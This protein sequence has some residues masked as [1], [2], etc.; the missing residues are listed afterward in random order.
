M[1]TFIIVFYAV[2]C[3]FFAAG[4]FVGEYKYENNVKR[5]IIIIFIGFNAIIAPFILLALLGEF[6]VTQSNNHS[7]PPKYDMCIC[8]HTREQHSFSK[9]HDE[10]DYCYCDGFT[11]RK[12]K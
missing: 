9:D 2:A 10:C 8:G 7:A 12:N 3:V 11:L 5:S 1:N 6:L 4:M